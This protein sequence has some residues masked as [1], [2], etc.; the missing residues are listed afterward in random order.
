M[1]NIFMAYADKDYV[2]QSVLNVFVNALQFTHEKGSIVL[3]MGSGDFIDPNGKQRS[4][5]W[6]SVKDTGE[7]IS[8]EKMATIFEPYSTSKKDPKN[9]GLGLSIVF[10]AI[11]ENEGKIDVESE[12]GKGTLFRLW[13]PSPPLAR[14]P[15]SLT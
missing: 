3:D 5:V 15:H 13:L 1:P 10:R 6:V 4:G 14:M 8:K 11:M 12:S 7:G 2:F 9:V